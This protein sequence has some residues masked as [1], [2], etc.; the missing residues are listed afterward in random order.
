MG[1]RRSFAWRAF[2]FVAI[3]L[4]IA[5]LL[6]SVVADLDPIVRAATRPWCPSGTDQVSTAHVETPGFHGWHYELACVS[7]DGTL[8]GVSPFLPLVTL[9]GVSFAVYAGT[10]LLICLLAPPILR[11]VLRR[12]ESARGADPPLA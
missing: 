12:R 7:A 9:L 10:V 6:T 4:L 3:G 5:A 8:T 11:R 1:A 2:W